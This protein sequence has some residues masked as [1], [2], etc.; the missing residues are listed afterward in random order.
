MA[1]SHAP[2]FRSKTLCGAFLSAAMALTGCAH[3]PEQAAPASPTASTPDAEVT[4]YS[5]EAIPFSQIERR[6]DPRIKGILARF[7]QSPLGEEM[8]QYAVDNDITFQWEYGRK[9]RKGAYYFANKKIVIDIIHSD[10][11]VL[12]TLAHEIRHAFQDNTLKIAYWNL[13][14]R[15]KWQA[16]QFMEADSCAFST[17]YIAEHQR[18]TNQTLRLDSSFNSDVTKSYMQKDA[19][20]RSYVKDALEPC[21]KLVV[22]YYQKEHMSVLRDYQTTYRSTFNSAVSSGSYSAALASGFNPASG[23]NKKSLF[24]RFMNLSF[25]PDGAQPPDTPADFMDWLEQQSAYKAP[26]DEEEIAAMQAEYDS[27]RQRMQQQQQ[28]YSHNMRGN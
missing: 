18:A 27:M 23:E 10:D 22:K 20:G 16:W 7:R 9:D 25:K 13:D 2:L 4:Q 1:K 11:G 5:V 26:A 28:R 17:Y 21:F 15:G 3:Q 12:T 24:L 6:G 8:Y 14:P 19:A